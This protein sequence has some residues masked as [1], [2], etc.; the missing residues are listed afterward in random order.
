MN[1]TD[2]QRITEEYLKPVYGFAL[3]RCRTH[4]DA[5]D[6]AQEIVTRA[7]SL[8]L[9]RDDIDDPGKFIWTMAHNAL[10]N[11]YRDN[12]RT[13][14]GIPVDETAE[15][16]PD[17]TDLEEDFLRREAI[18]K[19][20]SEIA[21]LSRLQRRIVI[22]NYFENKKQSDIARELNIPV[23]TVKWHLFEAKKELKRG[24]DMTRHPSDLKFNPIK[25]NSIGINGSVGTKTTDDFFRSVMNQNICY[26]VRNRAKT[27]NEIADDLGVSPVYIEEEA[28]YLE[29][30]GLLKKVGDGYIVNFLISEPTRELLVMQ[31][32]MYKKA[33]ALFAHELYDELIS[34][35]LL[36][37]KRI[38]CRQSGDAISLTQEPARDTNF[39]LWTLIPY[40][41]AQSGEETFEEKIP[42]DSVAT[43]RPDG[44]HNIFHAS[45][46]P[47]DLTLPDDY[48]Y[49]NGWCGPMRSRKHGLDLW[50]IDS[51]WSDR[52]EFRG[53]EFH[54]EAVRILDLYN[55]EQDTLL[56]PGDYA[57]L[58]EKGYMKTFGDPDTQF[59]T[60]WQIVVL[61][62]T[63]IKSRLLEIGSRIKEKHADEFDA[64]KAP[65]VTAVLDSVPAHLRRMKEYELQYT[66]H[67]D[68]WFL[69]HCVR[70]LLDSGKL[71]EPEEH[72]RKALMTLILPV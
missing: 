64:L 9:K 31:D 49:M 12:Q 36:D 13:F 33:A 61:E 17:G 1:R 7:F 63:D 19:L 67:S 66:F 69:L 70:E 30:Y 27:V 26:A 72:Q 2:A 38:R 55:Y 28:D 44:G 4:E 3:K 54:G 58:C 68:G 24:M 43:V 60:A 21:Y 52:G 71:K 18:L 22:A 42:F 6:L 40:I 32:A 39:I 11:Y 29:E 53:Q 15:L 16:I 25:F 45:V 41:I 37:D 56:T 57:W 10:A 5:E 48:V 34:S 47:D 20:R 14:T 65:Y 59:K 23:G 46:L 50:Q 62:D 35:G 8:L 51:E